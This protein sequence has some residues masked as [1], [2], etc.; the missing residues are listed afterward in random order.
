MLLMVCAQP[1]L[2]QQANAPLG[3]DQVMDLVKFGMDS[4]ELAKKIMD[5]GIDFDPSEEYVEALLKAGA[6][7]P[8][9][10]AI[11]QVRPIPLT[12]EQVGK[13]V[14]G[15][16]P[17]ERA[18]ALVKQHG[19][20]FQAD[21]KYLDTLRV[22]GADDTLISTLREA[23]KEAIV[24]MHVTTS[25]QA[26]VF[27]DGA[28]QG[29]ADA[30]GELL[31]NAPPG[32]YAL[33]VSLRGRKDFEQ[34]VTLAARRVMRIEAELKGFSLYV[35]ENPKDC[36]KYVWIPPGTF[37]MGCSHGDDECADS[38]KPA[39]QVAISRGFLIGQTPVTVSAYKR[40]TGA[41]GRQMPSSPTFN[42]GWANENMP[43]VRVTWDDAQAYCAWV[44]GRL[45][46][47]AEWEYAARGEST[48]ARY[49]PVDEV[50]WYDGNSGN[51]TYEVAQK[52]ANDF[53]LYDML[54]N[55]RQWCNDWYETKYYPSGSSQDPQGPESG[56][57]RVVR[58]GS[59][60]SKPL[61]V[62]VSNRDA[63][64]PTEGNSDIGFRCARDEVSK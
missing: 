13:L 41:M 58:G 23:S 29:H 18:A 42:L 16:V 51:Q 8:V 34:S 37:M 33:K 7:E 12:R 11:R 3:K 49:G 53:A 36:L 6:K 35:N 21:D 57:Q 62:R 10:H 31:V 56:L 30:R 9:I 4:T 38:E 14:A 60:V 20:A 26:E 5:R 32:A 47:E 24:E 54:G 22:A 25:P 19:I 48:E 45:P 50:A 15:G 52:R 17:Q 43:I 46:T 55:V 1:S 40:F 2:P 28:L 39:H 27:L 59:W 44:G 64:I 63:S 61:S